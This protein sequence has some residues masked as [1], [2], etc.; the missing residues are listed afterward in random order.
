MSD[1]IFI[2][3]AGGHF[4][5]LISV[6]DSLGLEIAGVYDESYIQDSEQIVCGQKIIGNYSDIKETDTILLAIGS[7]QR[8]YELFLKNLGNVYKSNLIHPASRIGSNVDIGRSNQ[9][10][11]N[12]YINSYSSLGEN[13]IINS[14]S[15]IE[16]ESKI[17]SHNHLSVG[18]II[19]GRVV[20]GDRC[21]LGAGS[22][23]I[24][25]ISICNNVIVGANSV[26]IKNISEPGTYVGNPARKIK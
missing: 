11:A 13:N 25:K 8:R 4:H 7:N 10:L 2:V 3:G 22:V 26:V 19:C 6:F 16:H 24:E 23:V 15:I 14:G 9:L 18:S 21:F 17:G 12:S 1:R 20:I 5:S